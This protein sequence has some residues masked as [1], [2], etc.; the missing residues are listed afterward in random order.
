VSGNLYYHQGQI[1]L[2]IHQ[3]MTLTGI[4]TPRYRHKLEQEVLAHA[5]ILCGICVSNKLSEARRIAGHALFASGPFFADRNEQTLILELLRSVE[6]ENGWPTRTV[7][8]ALV[9]EWNSDDQDGG[10]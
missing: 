4:G 7:T 8:S 6:K 3:P 10:C 2:L 5:R 1:L 9:K